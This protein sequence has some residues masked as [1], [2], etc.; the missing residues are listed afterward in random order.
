[1]P[2]LYNVVQYLLL[3]S[4]GNTI[5]KSSLYQKIL[6]FKEA[7][8]LKPYIEFNTAKRQP[9]RSKFKIKLY[10]DLCNSLFDMRMLNQR[11]YKDIKL[12]HE[13]KLIKHAFKARFDCAK[14]FENI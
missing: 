13:C 12:C 8:S 5:L 1:M 2:T 14:Q 6:R 10:K 4:I 3:S 11:K 9:A 7:A